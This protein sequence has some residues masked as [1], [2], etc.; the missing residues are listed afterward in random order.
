M[1]THHKLCRPLKLV[2]TI[3]GFWLQF[4]FSVKRNLLLSDDEFLFG[5]NAGV[6]N[7]SI[8][9]LENWQLEIFWK[10]IDLK[11]ILFWGECNMSVCR[12]H[13]RS[14]IPLVKHEVVQLAEAHQ[15]C[16]RKGKMDP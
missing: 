15:V 10:I 8:E 6:H 13:N 11:L 4:Y 3:H 12:H 9:L 1:C 14:L 16:R 7:I 5:N 2:I